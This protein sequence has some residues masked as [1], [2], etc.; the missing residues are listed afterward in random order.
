MENLQEFEGFRSKIQEKE[1]KWIKGA[2]EKPGALR[3]QLGRKEGEKITKG[4]IE[5]E[6]KKLRKED[7]EPE[8]KGIQGLSKP[9]L[10]K[11]RRLNLAKTLGE[12]GEGYEM[13]GEMEG[14]IEMEAPETTS[15]D[16][17]EFENYMFFQNMM[18]I[19]NMANEICRMD[20][21]EID[22]VLSNGH[23]WALDHTSTSKDD[24]EEVYH[25]L[26][27]KTEIPC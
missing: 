24:V 22:R 26:K 19:K 27:G 11:L 25:F 5:G 16:H 13:E 8:K 18:A 20:K 17:K 23:D 12:L 2:I 14:E 9:K 10:K 1:E 7:T 21:G 3:R 15:K 4:E 6:I